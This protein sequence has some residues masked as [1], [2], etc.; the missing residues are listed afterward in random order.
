MKYGK[1]PKRKAPARKSKQRTEQSGL[2]IKLHGLRST[3][4]LRAMLHEAVDRLEALGITHVRGVNLYV[5][6]S[7][8]KGNPLTHIGGAAIEDIEIEHPYRSAAEEHGL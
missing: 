8:K 6:L 2:R 7:D 1:R 4:D 3:K 5:T